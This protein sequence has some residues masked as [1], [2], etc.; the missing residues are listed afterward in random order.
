MPLLVL[1][2]W[3]MFDQTCRRIL[4]FLHKG[5]VRRRNWRNMLSWTEKKME[6]RKHKDD[7]MH[8]R[9]WC[10]EEMALTFHHCNWYNLKCIPL[11]LPDCLYLSLC[12]GIRKSGNCL[13]KSKTHWNK[14]HTPLVNAIKPFG[15]WVPPHIGILYSR[16]LPPRGAR[17]PKAITSLWGLW[18]TQSPCNTGAKKPKSSLTRGKLQLS[19]HFAYLNAV[20]GISLTS[21][22][23]T[24][25]QRKTVS[26]I[27]LVVWK[28]N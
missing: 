20:L 5:V 26:V 13:W 14:R 27:S 1:N 15:S 6:V 16:Q 23:C 4:F 3:A 7:R 9:A 25:N 17:Q 28:P 24:N 8:L 10:G 2:N 12:R 22:K 18:M 11:I 21:G 19:C